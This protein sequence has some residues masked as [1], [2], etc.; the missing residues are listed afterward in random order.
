MQLTAKAYFQDIAKCSEVLGFLNFKSRI[1]HRQY[2]HPMKVRIL[3]QILTTVVIESWIAS[4]EVHKPKT[5]EASRYHF[6]SDRTSEQKQRGGRGGG[7]KTTSK[8]SYLQ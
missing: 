5:E 4:F 8:H 3:F 6:Y 7:G 2:T 1:P